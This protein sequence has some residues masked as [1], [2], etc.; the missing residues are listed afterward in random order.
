M[1]C[2]PD[3][4]A[5]PLLVGGMHRSGTSLTAS[6]VASAGIDLGPE[7][8]GA[9]ASNPAGHFEDIG[10]Q[11]F[12]ER[13]LAAQGL[14]GEGYTATGRGRVP[15]ALEAEARDLLAARMR[16]GVAWGWKEPRTTLY[17]DFWQERL[18]DARHLFVFRRPWEVADSLF[19]RGDETFLLNPAFAFDVWTHYNRLILDF[20]QRHPERCVV[21]EISQVIADPIGTFAEVRTR[22]DVPLRRPARRYRDELFT[23]D[24][25]ST[26]AAL[27]RTI[28]PDAWTTYLELRRL[29]GSSQDVEVPGSRNVRVGDWAIHEWARASRAESDARRQAHGQRST[30][31]A[32]TP[33]STRLATGL[34]QASR[35][36]LRRLRPAARVADPQSLPFPCDGAPPVSRRAA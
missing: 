1:S 12:H 15:E 6:L 35:T 28:A 32:A 7:L 5:R 26:R 9:N 8:L 11:G 29:A 25:V 23:R 16:P 34:V 14:G 13:A 22:L 30:V 21:L 17:L 33:L 18:P 24:D 20:V 3:I 27:V 36:L 19:R 4:A 10:F 2:A 31:P